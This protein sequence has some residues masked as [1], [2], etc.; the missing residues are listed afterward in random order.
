MWLESKDRKRGH[1]EDTLPKSKRRRL[2]SV[3]LVVG[4]TSDASKSYWLMRPE[5]LKLGIDVVCKY[6][7]Y[8]SLEPINLQRAA[9]VVVRLT[10]LVRAE[11]KIENAL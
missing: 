11:G 10:C 9:G 6:L 4:V 5:I 8:L 1:E 7:L 2:H 3:A